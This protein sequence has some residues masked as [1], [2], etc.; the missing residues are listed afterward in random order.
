MAP[1]I[2]PDAE[3]PIMDPFSG[4]SKGWVTCSLAIGLWHQIKSISEQENNK[5]EKKE[6]KENKE[7]NENKKKIK[8]E[9]EKLENIKVKVYIKNL[10]YYLLY[11]YFYIY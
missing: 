4:I 10:I 9:D 8:N 3:Y 1:S 2:L 11:I 6:N 7:E 5:N